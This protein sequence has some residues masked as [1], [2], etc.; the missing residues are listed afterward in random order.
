MRWPSPVPT[1]Y[2]GLEWGKGFFPLLAL[3]VL[4]ARLSPADLCLGVGTH[5]PGTSLV[6]P[7]NSLTHTTSSA[8]TLPPHPEPGQAD[9]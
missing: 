9:Y 6:T 5:A 4:S 7:E 2:H 3:H 1:P 8:P